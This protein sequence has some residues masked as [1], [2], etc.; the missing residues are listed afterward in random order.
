MH[1]NGRNCK[2][3]SNH[4]FRSAVC[5]SSIYKREIRLLRLVSFIFVFSSYFSVCEPHSRR[6]EERHYYSH[7]DLLGFLVS[8]FATVQQCI[9]LICLTFLP[10]NRKHVNVLPLRFDDVHFL[11]YAP[12]NT[13]NANATEITLRLEMKNDEKQTQKSGKEC[14]NELIYRKTHSS[15]YTIYIQFD[16]NMIKY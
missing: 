8:L 6:N 5:L 14:S 13:N 11:L 12:F 2:I 16:R 3:S 15:I 7:V 4:R 10:R 1:F 9:L